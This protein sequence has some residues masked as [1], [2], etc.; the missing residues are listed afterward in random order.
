MDTTIETTPQDIFHK[1]LL[2]WPSAI[3]ATPEVKRF[4][5]GIIDGKTLA[6]MRSKGE[7]VPDSVKIGVKRAYSAESLVDWLRQRTEGRAI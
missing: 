3:V 7:P 5:G 6:N 2:K 1:M 4:T